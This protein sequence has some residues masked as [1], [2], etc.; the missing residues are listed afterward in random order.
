M[1]GGLLGPKLPFP[2]AIITHLDFIETSLE[3]KILNSELQ[4]DSFSTL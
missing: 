3:V 2:A 4:K 1:I